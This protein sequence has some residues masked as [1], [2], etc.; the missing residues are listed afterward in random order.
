M[1][2]K[3]V[4]KYIHGEEEIKSAV[5]FI[6]VNTSYNLCQEMNIDEKREKFDPF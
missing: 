2:Q 6:L 5:D 4:K 3:I 1:I